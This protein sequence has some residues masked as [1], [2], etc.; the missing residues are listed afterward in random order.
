V[1]V[2]GFV[3]TIT[4]LSLSVLLSTACVVSIGD[5]E[6]GS[7]T[8]SG[9][10]GNGGDGGASGG[11]GATGGVAGAMIDAGAGG[12]PPSPCPPDKPQHNSTCDNAVNSTFCLYGNAGCVCV[13]FQNLWYCNA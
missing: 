2:I 7:S 10:E 12:A 4:A 6:S 8:A 13:S 9:G 3:G 5:V 1:R 11:D